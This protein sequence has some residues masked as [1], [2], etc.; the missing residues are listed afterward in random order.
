MT[1]GIGQSVLRK[2]DLRL[3]TGR[4][5]F[6]DD[7][8]LPGQLHATM[9]RSPHAHAR[10]RAI[11]TERAKQSPGVVAVLTGRDYAEDGLQPIPRQAF[12]PDLPLVNPDGS[13]C[14]VPPDFPIVIEKVRHVGEVVA[15]VVAQTRMAALD[16]A[17]Q[18]EVDYDILPAVVEVQ[19]A[20]APGAL[21]CGKV[22]RITSPSKEHA[23]I[24]LPPT[25]PLPVP[26]M[27]REWKSATIASRGFR[28]SQR[29]RSRVT[30]WR[31]AA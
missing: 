22:A 20:V 13:P 25:R 12:P 11:R 16:A 7:L 9:V 1:F 14:F 30:M 19:D 21:S 28:S 18:L 17:E 26:P 5:E 6:S 24:S 27:S 29:P 2:E 4:G 10:I 23:G 31:A 15:V 3:L 8:D